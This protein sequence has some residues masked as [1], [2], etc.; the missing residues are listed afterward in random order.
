MTDIDNLVKDLILEVD[1]SKKKEHFLKIWQ[2]AQDAGVYPAS[3]HDFYIARGKGEFSGFTVPAINIRGLTYVL[4]RAIIRVAKKHNAGAFIFEIAKSEMGYTDQRPVEYCGVC[5]AAAVKEGYKGPIFIQADHT[6][7]NPKKYKESPNK[8]MDNL[9]TLIKEAVDSGFYNIDI[10]SSTLVDLTKT[11]KK[12]EQRLNYEACAELTKYIRSIEP[13]G[14]TVS[15][16]GEIGEVGSANSTPEELEAFMDGYEE[17]LGDDAG[18]SKVSVQ[19]GTSHG[20]IVLPDGSIAK[21]KLDFDTLKILSELARV[22]HGM[23]GAVQHGAS[24]LPDDAFGKFPEV[25]TVEVHLATQ[26]QNMIFESEAFP[27]EL[28]KK[29]YSWLGE[30]L[31][32]EKKEGETEDQFIYKTRKKALGA[33]KNDLTNLSDEIHSKIGKELED[34]F[35]FLF[36]KLKIQNTKELIDKYIKFVKVVPNVTS[37]AGEIDASGAD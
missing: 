15:V 17:Y 9:K 19:T 10:D 33:F 12:E 2:V 21:V 1:I 16:G 23:G 36:Q 35:D 22:K 7:V 24:T 14:I 6:Q 29:I 20:G 5:L 34:K 3:I 26:F 37:H 13:E 30:N 25:E 18:M 27:V 28:K 32:S 31:S 11:D 4:A 8:E